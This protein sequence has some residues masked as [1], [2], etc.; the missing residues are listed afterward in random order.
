MNIDRNACK[1]MLT[2]LTFLIET[3]LR[4]SQVSKSLN[5]YCYAQLQNFYAHNGMLHLESTAASIH[6]TLT[7]DTLY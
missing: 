7:L 4:L 3:E 1:S 6:R 5:G 2:L